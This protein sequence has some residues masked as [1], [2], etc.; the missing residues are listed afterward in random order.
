MV[1]DAGFGHPFGHF[2]CEARQR[3]KN[4]DRCVVDIH[5][6]A[7][8]VSPGEIW[9]ADQQFSCEGGITFEEAPGFGPSP[10]TF[11]SVVNGRIH[12]SRR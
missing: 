8:V 6:A 9:S 4:R 11:E 7:V 12:S 3:G 1:L 5:E 2:R 10:P